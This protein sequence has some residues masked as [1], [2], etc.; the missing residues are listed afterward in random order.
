[1]TAD[2]R[3]LAVRLDR[4]AANVRRYRQAAH[5]LIA[6]VDHDGFGLGL[7]PVAR[8][9]A[10]AG[11]DLL[12]VADFDEAVR[13][14]AAGVSIPLLAFRPDGAS[15][16]GLGV[17]AAAG[18]RAEAERALDRGADG[19]HTVI[20]CGGARRGFAPDDA[21]GMA[22]VASIAPVA[23]LMGVADPRVARDHA[24]DALQRA[25]G[26][27]GTGVPAHLHGTRGVLA[28]R[29]ADDEFVRVGRG[30]YGIPYPDGTATGSVVARLTGRVVLTKRIAA[31]EGV[32]YG[33]IYRAEK[34]GRIALVTCGYAD[35]VPRIVGND[36]E[37]A[38][39]GH[40][41]RVIGRVAMD[42]VVVDLGGVTAQSGDEVVFLGDPAEG[43]PGLAEWARITGRDTVELAATIG[44][45]VIRSYQR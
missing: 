36:A 21:S 14:R 22:S 43:E 23:A 40:R 34:D 12:A 9:C 16:A 1:M 33:Y 32:S 27:I 44:P 29:G 19:I 4:L 17:V 11:A 37:V 35:G 20:D 3:R 2:S 30:L 42:V 8:E 5:G 7:V 24:G 18:T 38:I 10:D 45:R 6:R 13:V 25:R 15:V 39:G 31:G 26:T 41:A 28:G